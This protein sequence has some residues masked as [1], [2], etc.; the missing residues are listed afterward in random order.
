[1][2]HFAANDLAAFD[3]VSGI[4]TEDTTVGHFDA[5]YAA[6]CIAIPPGAVVESADFINPDTGAT[7]DLT[8]FWLH[9]ELVDY[10]NQQSTG[11]SLIEFYTAAGVAVL[12][13][14][15]PVN[16]FDI[17]VEYWDGAAWVPGASSHIY[18]AQA[19][20]HILDF[21][22]VCGA[23]GSVTI[24]GDNN[25]SALQTGL[26]A[27]VTSIRYMRLLNGGWNFGAKF[28][29]ILVSSVTTVGAK[30]A[31]LTP[32]ANSAVNTAWANDYTKLVELGY[33]DATVISSA[34]TGDK[35]T[36][37]CTDATLPGISYVISSV[38]WNA[39]TILGG[40]APVNVK[41]MVRIAGVDYAGAYNIPNLTA[42]SFGAGICAMTLDPST[43]AA[44]TIANV[45]AAEIGFQ[46]AA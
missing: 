36:Y 5:I 37:G 7:V 17:R 20:K 33:S 28:S 3:I 9:F 29:Q 27:A 19:Q 44:W 25:F 16:T 40:S 39:R 26:N 34:A 31:S 22:F 24:Y 18:S 12:R 45:N 43:A 38:W 41:P 23:G 1:M 30:V 4:P 8:D 46:S 10:A 11:G 42:A 14:D 2:D 35:E 21:H 6:K 13:I 32:N 15:C